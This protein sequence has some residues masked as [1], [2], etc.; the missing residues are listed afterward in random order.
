MIKQ[1]FSSYELNLMAY[2]V[3]FRR[4]VLEI[5]EREG[6]SFEEAAVR[7]GVG[8]ASVFRWSKRLFPCRKRNKPAVKID[9]AALAR[10]VE[11][12]PDAYQ[13]E[14]ADRLGCSQRGISDAL[15][16]LR[17]SR[18]KKLF[19]IRKRMKP[20]EIFSSARS[21]NIRMMKNL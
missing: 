2:S 15:K 4:K 14:R 6:L 10:D 20:H 8:Q 21:I 17:I 18:K 9:M 13:H 19:S 7:F 3:D 5:K 16:R 12:Q 1:S 11:E